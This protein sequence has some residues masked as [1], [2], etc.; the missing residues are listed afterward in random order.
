MATRNVHEIEITTPDSPPEFLY[1]AI[2]EEAHARAFASGESARVKILDCYRTIEDD[3]RRDESEGS[4]KAKIFQE[5][6]VVRTGNKSGETN[7]SSFQ[8][9]HLNVHSSSGNPTFVLC[10]AGT[11]VD[12]GYLRKEMGQ[13]VVKI[14]D[15]DQL[16]NDVVAALYPSPLKNCSAY[17]VELAP[18]S[19]NKGEVDTLPDDPN[20]RR[21]EIARRSCLQ[22]PAKYELEQEQRL[23]I[24][25][26]PPR[27][28]LK[29]DEHFSLSL[30]NASDYCEVLDPSTSS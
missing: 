1:R 5:I 25:F 18:V 16:V 9:G 29:G 10:M 27:K 13:Y 6:E 26:L 22:K 11:N 24:K 17:A 20:D 4:Y 28:E 3:A 8:D 19:Y 15:P 7:G 12:L 14:S 23:V 30:E 2:E 21:L